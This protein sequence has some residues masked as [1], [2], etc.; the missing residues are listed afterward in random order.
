MEKIGGIIRDSHLKLNCTLCSVRG[1]LLFGLTNDYSLLIEDTGYVGQGN[2][3]FRCHG[4]FLL[5]FSRYCT[6]ALTQ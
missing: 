2:C 5:Q 6:E 3:I 1:V 4:G